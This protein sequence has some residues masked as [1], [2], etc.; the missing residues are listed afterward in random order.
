MVSRVAYLTNLE[1]ESQTQADTLRQSSMV[2]DN[3]S[4]LKKSVELIL[5]FN[6]LVIV[7]RLFDII[8]LFLL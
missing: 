3:I 5:S 8:C 6:C 7:Y 1:Q 2:L 4:A